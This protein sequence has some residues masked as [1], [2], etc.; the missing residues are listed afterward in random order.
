M[1]SD[2]SELPAEL[3]AFLHSCIESITQI[4]VLM[5]LRGA[6]R[7]RTVRE[8]ADALR[9]SSPNARRDLDILA[10]RGLL[11]VHVGSEVAYRYRPKTDDLGRYSDLLAEHYVTSREA[12]FGYI[13][14]QSRRSMKRF[15]DAFRLR[16]DR[17]DRE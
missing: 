8:V 9:L 16:D 17:S 12:V 5:L 3:R 14:T 2:E 4:E 1:S 11:E 10:A 7:A 6:L 13:A 15:S